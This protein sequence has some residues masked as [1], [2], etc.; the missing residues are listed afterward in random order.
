MYIYQLP[1]WPNFI[2]DTEV[3]SPLLADVRFKQGKLLGGME[4]LG[5]DLKSEAILQTLIQD[6]TKSSEI[7]GEILDTGQVRSSIARR[8]GMDVAGLVPSDRD[9]DGIVEMMLDATQQFQDSLN[10]ER[11]FGWHASF[12]LPKE[13]DLFLNWVNLEVDID[14]ILKAA[15][16]HLWFVTLHP[17]T[18]VSYIQFYIYV[19]KPNTL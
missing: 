8:L 3:L 19:I 17:L 15:I 11:L 1:G 2:W 14:P 9:V 5:F 7:E 18:L 12:K 6:V 13:V 4:N 10:E 16:A